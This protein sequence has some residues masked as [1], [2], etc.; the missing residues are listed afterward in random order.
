M[1]TPGLGSVTFWV[2]SSFSMRTGPS[3]CATI[4]GGAAAPVPRTGDQ[5]PSSNPGEVHPAVSLRA[6]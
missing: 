4:R 2:R 1:K 3:T 6:S 5:A